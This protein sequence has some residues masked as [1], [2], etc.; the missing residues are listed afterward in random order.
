MVG[1]LLSILASFGLATTA[2][3]TQYNNICLSLTTSTTPDPY[4][5]QANGYFY[6]TFTAGNRV[7]IWRVQSLVD[8]RSNPEK[9]IIWRPPPDTNYSCD[10]WAPELHS[11]NG[12]WYVYVAGAHPQRGNRSHRMYVLGGPPSTSDPTTSDWTFLGPIANLDQAQWAIDATVISLNH[13]LYF[14][15]SGWPLGELESEL[16]QELFIVRLSDPVTADSPPTRLCHPSEPWERSDRSGI[17]EGPQVLVSPDGSWTGIVY[18]CAGS[19]TKDYKMNTLQ[20][21]GGDP[22]DVTAWKKGTNPLITTNDSGKG[23]WGPGHGSVIQLGGETFVVYHATDSPDDGWRNRR[24]RIQRLVFKGG[25]PF[26]GGQ[27][28]PL[29]DSYAEFMGEKRKRD[30]HST[31]HGISG[32]MQKIKSTLKDEL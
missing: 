24:A 11:L 15:Y 23:P 20:Y 2:E 22:L 25:Q 21:M 19:W 12:R 3:M 14:I 31:K 32:I 28:G 17:N 9:H 16:I 30:S 13:Q 5:T 8:F 18:S 1:L 27:V 7:E 6:M 4:V 29:T 10:L 26:M